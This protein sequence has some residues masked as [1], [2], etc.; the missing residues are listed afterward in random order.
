MITVSIRLF[1]VLLSEFVLH[2]Q[3]SSWTST[4]SSFCVFDVRTVCK[5]TAVLF[6]VKASSSSTSCSAVLQCKHS[7]DSLWFVLFSLKTQAL[8][9]L[10]V[11][12]NSFFLSFSLT[13]HERFF[14]LE[15]TMRK[16]KLISRAWLLREDVFRRLTSLPRSSLEFDRKGVVDFLLKCSKKKLKAL[17]SNIH[18]GIKIEDSI[19]EK[20]IESWMS[21]DGQVLSSH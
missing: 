3:S 11:E 6:P 21:L 7:L 8:Y 20:A 14:T 5:L 18:E 16:Q 9:Y 10:P 4:S 19:S 1:P 15:L 2:L 13:T 17:L 12:R